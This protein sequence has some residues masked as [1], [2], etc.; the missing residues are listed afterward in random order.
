MHVDKRVSIFVIDQGLLCHLACS[1]DVFTIIRAEFEI[2]ETQKSIR[3]YE[4]EYT[5]DRSPRQ[6]LQKKSKVMPKTQW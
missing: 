6:Q 1:I 5:I 2:N 4:E 3:R